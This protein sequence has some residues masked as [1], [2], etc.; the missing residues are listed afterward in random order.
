MIEMELIGHS[1]IGPKNPLLNAILYG[2]RRFSIGKSDRVASFSQFFA[3]TPY[4]FGRSGPLPIAEEMEDLQW[5]F[6]LLFEDLLSLP[7]PRSGPGPAG[8]RAG[9]VRPSI[10]L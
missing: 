2:K 3:K 5:D 10:K 9:E 4:R 6:P 7:R 8:R 1:Y